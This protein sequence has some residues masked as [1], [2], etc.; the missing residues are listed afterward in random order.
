MLCNNS[1][2]VFTKYPA[3]C[4]LETRHGVN[5]R[6]SYRNENAGKTLCLFIAQSRWEILWS[7]LGFSLLSLSSLIW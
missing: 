4:G 6:T 2:T 3:L 5:V 1:D 7:S